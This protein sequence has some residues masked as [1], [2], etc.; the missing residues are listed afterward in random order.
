MS[1]RNDDPKTPPEK[2]NNGGSSF[3]HMDD[4]EL[5]IVP[6]PPTELDFSRLD[7]TK[8]AKREM[9]RSGKKDVPESDADDT[10]DIGDFDHTSPVKKL[11]DGKWVT[12]READPPRPY[13]SSDDTSTK[14]ELPPGCDYHPTDYCMDPERGSP[15]TI[16]SE[17]PRKCR[18]VRKDCKCSLG[19]E[20]PYNIDHILRK[21]KEMLSIEHP[22]ILDAGVAEVYIDDALVMVGNITPNRADGPKSPCCGV[23]MVWINAKQHHICPNCGKPPGKKKCECHEGKSLGPGWPKCPYCGGELYTE[24]PEEE[25]EIHP[26]IL[27]VSR[28]DGTAHYSTE[29]GQQYLV[30]FIGLKETSYEGPD[31]SPEDDAED[32]ISYLVE[33]SDHPDDHPEEPRCETGPDNKGNCPYFPSY[34]TSCQKI[35]EDR[36]CP[37]G[38]IEEGETLSEPCPEC[39]TSVPYGPGTDHENHPTKCPNCGANMEVNLDG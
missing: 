29:D 5:G 1:S 6:P 11:V 4:I 34:P 23:A 8:I 9:E 15:S 14:D 17:E 31:P 3:A 30:T 12:I 19:Y 39:N 25:P 24:E 10:G 20:Y 2:E 28:R 37:A 22:T 16:L 36:K 27:K 18:D 7:E 26:E 21:V 13:V 35:R 32:D 33:M 38:D